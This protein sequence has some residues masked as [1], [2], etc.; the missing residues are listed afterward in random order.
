VKC[1]FR[2]ILLIMCRDPVEG[3]ISFNGIFSFTLV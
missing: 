2:E 3:Y 1:S